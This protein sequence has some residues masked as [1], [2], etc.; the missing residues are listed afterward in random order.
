MI[1]YT[2][3]ARTLDGSVLAEGTLPGVEG[4]HPQISN[5]V[6]SALRRNPTLVTVGNRKTFAY[7]AFSGTEI[8]AA[9]GA[10]N[11]GFI[12][13]VPNPID[14]IWNGLNAI[15]GFL[16]KV[17]AEVVTDDDDDDDESDFDPR[18]NT[19]PIAGKNIKAQAN[20]KAFLGYYF[21]VSMA[22]YVTFICLSDDSVTRQQNV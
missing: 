16:N 18:S 1:L 12:Q 17:V 19:L 14:G 8:A 11:Q 10:Q 21:H 7:S 22:E 6:I 2:V 15:D 13:L 20:N 4:N 9:S 3:I 5:E